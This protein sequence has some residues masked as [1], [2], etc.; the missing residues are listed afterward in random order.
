MKPCWTKNSL[1]AYECKL[2]TLSKAIVI[3]K[4]YLPGQKAYW[5]ISISSYLPFTE[6]QY[7]QAFGNPE[8]CTLY[9]EGIVLE[10]LQSLALSVHNPLSSEQVPMLDNKK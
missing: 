3:V 9:A 10:W 1:G 5:R 4:S 7:N 8:D 6:V 2:G